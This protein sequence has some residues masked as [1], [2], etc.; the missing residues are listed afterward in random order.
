LSANDTNHESLQK[1]RLVSAARRV[2]VD[3]STRAGL[4]VFVLTRLLILAVILLSSSVVFEPT[5][6]TP[7]GAVHESAVSLHH[8]SIA[9]ILRRV[10]SGAD[11]GWLMNIAINGYEKEP[12][13]TAT[14]HAWA[15]FPLYPLLWRWAAK[16]TGEFPLTG[17][18]LS[19]LFL[20]AALILLHRTVGAFGYEQGV[21]DRAI[22]YVAAFPAGYFFSLAQTESLFLLLTVSC[23][24]AAKRE[25]WWLAGIVGALA[26]AT[27]FAGVFLLI[28][29][30][31]LYWQAYRTAAGETSSDSKRVPGRVKANSVALLLVPLGLFVYMLYLKSI[32]GDAFAFA[33]IQVAWGHSAGFFWRPIFTYLRDPLLLSAGWDFRLLNFAAAVMA[34]ICAAVLLKRSEW[35]LG[36]F[37]AVSILVPMSTQPLLQSLARYVMVIFPVFIV[38]ALA[39]HSPRVDQTIRAVFIGLLCL[40]SAMLAAG[41]TLAFA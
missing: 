28:P 16:L 37:A 6:N 10:T 33:H 8:Q 9:E 4:F 39:G 23:L 25:R 2:A 38:L 40:M 13:N 34:L 1:R 7:F 11:S 17:V 14:Q 19:N 3:P 15:Y 41:V 30:G 29:L 21:A 35:A 27:R 20:L 36:L 24:N 32:T 26:S 31:V 12:F 18:F 5:V 22:F